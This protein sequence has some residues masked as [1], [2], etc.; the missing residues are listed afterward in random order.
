MLVPSQI[1]IFP[2]PQPYLSSH[3]PPSWASAQCSWG[4]PT[5]GHMNLQVPTPP[6][7]SFVR[8]KISNIS[9]IYAN[10][11]GWGTLKT[12][13]GHFLKKN[14]RARQT[15]QNRGAPS[16]IYVQDRILTRIEKVGHCE[17]GHLTRLVGSDKDSVFLLLCSTDFKNIRFISGS[18]RWWEVSSLEQYFPPPKKD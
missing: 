2:L 5:G 13:E 6:A 18:G 4:W 1:T 17:V 16:K 12:K 7:C 3:F 9:W 10:L 11:P 8:Y 14:A 15:A